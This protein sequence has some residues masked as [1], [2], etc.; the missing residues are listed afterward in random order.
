[1]PPDAPRRWAAP[2]LLL[3]VLAVY[4]AVLPAGFIG[5]DDPWLVLE[6]PLLRESSPRALIAV[7]T[8]LD[9]ATRMVLG[10]E[11]LPVRDTFAWLTARVGGISGPAFHAAQLAVYLGAVALMR[12]WLHRV[13]RDPTVAELAAWLFALHP[14]HVSSVAWVA[15]TKDALSLLFLAGALLVHAGT[16]RARAPAVALLT[17]LACLSKGTSVVAPALLIASDLLARRRVAWGPVAAS[18]AVALGSFA[19][20]M[21]VGRV[22]SMIAEPL[23]RNALER[24]ASMAPVALRYLRISLLLDPP[25]IVREVD[26]RTLTDPVALASLAALAGLVAACGFAWRRGQRLPLLA[27]GVFA[28]GLA[29]VSQ[30]LVPLQNR[31]ADRYLLVAV[32]GPCLV[33]AWGIPRVPR[34]ALARA[35]GAVALLAAALS[36]AAHAAQFANEPRLWEDA[37]ARVPRSPLAPYQLAQWRQSHGDPQGAEAMF[38]E[39]LARDGMRTVTSSFAATNLSR[40]LAQRGRAEEAIALLRAVVA[41]F[42]QNPRALNNLA[43]LLELR[44][45]RAEA[46]ALFERLVRRFPDY[47]RGRDAWTRRYGPLPAGVATPSP[48]GTWR[49]DPYAR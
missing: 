10:A 34:V 17:A 44:G 5:Y 18:A 15:G 25:C 49:F 33:A 3:A 16:S 14:A 6:N 38:R 48:G 8:R 22:V 12:A 30:V 36:S 13:L 40:L 7:W 1:M 45:D 27:L 20:Q 23:G 35:L 42:P 29:P 46:R 21:R 41:R 26:A 31:M 4:A 43:T 24:I 9:L 32:L 39:A 19:L 28:A 11:F 2:A 47:A 37:L